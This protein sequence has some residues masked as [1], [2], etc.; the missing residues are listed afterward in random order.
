MMPGKCVGTSGSR[1]ENVGLSRTDVA[2]FQSILFPFDAIP[3]EI[4]RQT[5]PVCFRDLNLDQV[6]QVVMTGRAEY[7]L[8][9]FFYWPCRNVGAVR[10]RHDIFRDLER[11]ELRASVERFASA[12]QSLRRMLARVDSIYYERQRQR[13][14][15]D[16]V[17]TYTD[18][19]RQFATDL[20]GTDPKAAGMQ[21]LLSYLAAY[22]GSK[23]FREMKD[24]AQ[25]LIDELGKIRY[26]LH[27]HGKRMTVRRYEPEPDYSADVLE[28]FEKFRQRA[29]KEYRFKLHSPA[30]MNQVE[31]AILDRVA[32]LYPELFAAL[33]DF[34]ARYS[35]FMDAALVRFDR[36]VQFYLAWLEHVDR[37]KEL[38]LAFSYP[39][40]SDVSKEI[41]AEDSFDLALAEARREEGQSVVTNSFS[42][43]G[44]ERVLVVTGPNQGG[45]TT[46]ARMFGQLH[47]LAALGCPVPA[48]AARLFLFDQ[49]FTHFERSEAVENLRGKLEDELLRI[50][51]ILESATPESILI[52]NE[53]FLSTTLE[54]ALLLSRK[55]MEKIVLR[56]MLCLS[57]TFLDEMTQVKGAVSM[58]GEVDPEDPSRKTF[59]IC[60]R[61]ADG[62]A[63]AM[64]IAKKYGLTRDEI[65]TRIAR[66]AERSGK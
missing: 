33:A 52:M 30:E 41:H 29:S 10:Y 54:D 15:L 61:P 2:N 20:E 38:S 23:Q 65:Q 16:A 40:V 24:A 7:N 60:R 11:R 51:H 46:F 26:S 62:L 45:K 59:R 49:L 27:I 57:V 19:I 4:D 14:L 47:F 17:H 43:S 21:E 36:E 42:L 56:D 8:R 48:K 44:E 32:L 31:A 35:S 37:F 55:T 22:I 66:N 5:E 18:G 53:S 3:D 1:K 63:Y 12:M 39:E 58:V 6:V 50:R 9:S 34:S 64:T 25:H 13:C 28:A